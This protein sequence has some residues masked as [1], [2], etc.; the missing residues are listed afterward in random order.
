MMLQWLL[1]EMGSGSHAAGSSAA[2]KIKD[3]RKCTRKLLIAWILSLL[4][5]ALLACSSVTNLGNQVGE[6]SAAQSVATQVD[7]AQI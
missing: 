6:R 7:Q 3:E 1:D 2:V 5:A 4:A